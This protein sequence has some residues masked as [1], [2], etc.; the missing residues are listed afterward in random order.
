[1]KRDPRKLERD[2]AS[3]GSSV[4]ANSAAWIVGLFVASVALSALGRR[5]GLPIP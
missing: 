2:N 3:F 4:S 5:L 1:M